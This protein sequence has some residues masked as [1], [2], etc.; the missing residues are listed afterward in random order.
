MIAAR[1]R[2]LRSDAVLVARIDAAYARYLEPRGALL[3]GDVQP[4]NILL[5]A[6]GPK[7]LD[8]EIA[9][10]G[11]PAFDIGVA[12]GHLLLAALARGDATLAQPAVATLWIEY[13]A[14]HGGGAPKFGEAARYAGIEML[15]RTIGAA[16]VPGVERDEVALAVLDT[17]YRLVAE[18]PQAL[19]DFTR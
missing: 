4:T 18:P 1:A 19:A 7:L 16:R 5:T 2:S 6:T 15:R 10:V 11:D 13:T 17:G 9:H 12:L 8:A 14:A 3:H